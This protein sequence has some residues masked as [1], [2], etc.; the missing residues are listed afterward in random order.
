MTRDDEKP[1]LLLLGAGDRRYREYILA[2]VAQHY[3]LWMLSSEAAAWHTEY[4]V[5][6]SQLDPHDLA[7]ILDAVRVV[8]DD[9]GQPA[10]VLCYDEWLIHD[11]ARLACELGLPGP[12]PTAVAVCRDKS[13]TRQVLRAAGIP[14][15]G[16][17]A[18]ATAEQAREVADAFGYPV[19]LKARSLAGSIGVVRVDSSRSIS[20]AYAV[21]AREYLGGIAQPQPA[22][23][24]EEY[25]DG[26]EISIDAMSIDGT[27]HVMVL[28]RKTLGFAPYF[29]ELG[30]TVSATDPLLDNGVLVHQL[31]Q[32]H[33]A[34]GIEQTVTHSEFRLTPN[35]PRLV[36]INARL[37]GDFIPRLGLL[38][39]GLD[40]A[41]VIADVAV[42]LPP[43]LVPTCSRAAGIRFFYP[44]R[45]CRACCVEILPGHPTGIESIVATVAAG[46]ELRPPPH[47]FLSRYGYA[48]A[49]APTLGKVQDA[50]ATADNYLNLHAEPL[51]S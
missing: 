38:A 50:L 4:L 28:A 8:A 25:L 45:D 7:A 46:Q 18:V 12:D 14:Q 16:S 29:E 27:T 49:V 34:V 3:R 20:Q 26:Q 35:G 9:Q 22:V 33:R 41:R 6:S 43:N 30:H 5:G 32:I 2:S 24:V 48:V 15:P 37:G 51:A 42:G 23:L 19:V 47:A 36:E 13:Q 44:T 11:A 1:L 40:V 39:T 31:E 21:A 17:A 10:G